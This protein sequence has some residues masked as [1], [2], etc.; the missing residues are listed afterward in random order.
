LAEIVSV[1]CFEENKEMK[2]NLVTV[3]MWK[4]PDIRKT[5]NVVDLFMLRDK[6]RL[7]DTED[8]RKPIQENQV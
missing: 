4:N 2:D 5:L 8:I 7:D 6:T 3:E 1:F